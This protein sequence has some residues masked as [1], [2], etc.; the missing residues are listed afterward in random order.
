[1]S[2]ARRSPHRFIEQLVAL[3][4]S[5][6]A[7]PEAAEQAVLDLLSSLA[8]EDY[9]TPLEIARLRRAFN[10][11]R[12]QRPPYRLSVPVIA[13]RLGVDRTT[14]YRDLRSLKPNKAA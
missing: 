2:G 4:E 14:I 5:L 3:L 9:P 6:G 1:M 7:P 10:V 13:A 8:P 12:L 11:Q